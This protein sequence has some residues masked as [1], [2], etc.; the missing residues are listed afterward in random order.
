MQINIL[1]RV[2]EAT[3][4]LKQDVRCNHISFTGCPRQLHL[5]YSVS[6][7]T[8]WP[9]QPNILCRV[10]EATRSLIQGVEGNQ[11]FYTG[12][13]RQPG[14][15]C[16]QIS[17]TG[18]QRQPCL[19]TVWLRQQNLLCRISEANRSLVQDVHDNLISYTGCPRQPVLLYGV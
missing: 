10:S 1:Y 4:S 6:E 19:H 5:L 12:C 2:S 15:R 8:R 7:A 11:I 13:P 14:G 9:R 17:Y 18:C 16:N 3:I